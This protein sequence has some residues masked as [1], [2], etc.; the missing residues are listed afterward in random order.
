MNCAG[1]VKDGNPECAIKLLA[2]DV[3]NSCCCITC[4]ARKQ[5]FVLNR[6]NIRIL[7]C[8]FD[9]IYSTVEIKYIL[10]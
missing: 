9:L 8:Y 5:C 7:R 10:I 6:I 4:K 3:K 2:A 1:L